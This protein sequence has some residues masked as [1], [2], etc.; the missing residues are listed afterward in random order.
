[1]SKVLHKELEPFNVR[2]LL[3][4]LGTFNTPMANS[5]Q[6]IA[7]P[8]D[9]DY[10]GTQTERLFNMLRTGDFAI[11]GD[12]LKATQAV[13][14]VV[15]DEGSAKGLGSE[16]MLPLGIDLANTVKRTQDRLAHM[17]DVFGGICHNVNLDG[18]TGPSW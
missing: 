1:M 7:A 13:Y 9:P 4:Y 2:V 5:V 17:M 6:A 11:P 3:V 14:D 16:I 10:E 12:H 18:G 8:L 15:M